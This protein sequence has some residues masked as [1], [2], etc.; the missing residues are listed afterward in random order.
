VLEDP[1]L[2]QVSRITRSC[3]GFKQGGNF[4]GSLDEKIREE[5]G[6]LILDH[7]IMEHVINLIKLFFKKNLVITKSQILHGL[8]KT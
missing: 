5:F 3:G 1:I 6:D 2:S 7:T 8:I 4:L